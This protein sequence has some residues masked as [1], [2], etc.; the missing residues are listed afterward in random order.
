MGPQQ[1][2][3]MQLRIGTNADFWRHDCTHADQCNCIIKKKCMTNTN[4]NGDE[5]YAI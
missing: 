2:N 3:Y 4:T 5:E 1:Q